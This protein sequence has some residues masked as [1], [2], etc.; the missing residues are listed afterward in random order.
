MCLS[1]PVQTHRHFGDSWG[2]LGSG[3]NRGYADQFGSGVYACTE[4]SR[5]E[6]E[7]TVAAENI[8]EFSPV[9]I[10]SLWN[11]EARDFTP[12][13][14]REDNLALLSSV[15]GMELEL[16]GVQV[17]VGPYWADIVAR[18]TNSD[19]LVVIENQLEKTNHDHLG[20]VLTYA[21]GL[22]SPAIV[23]IAREFSEDHR[24]AFDFLNEK[25]APDLRCFGI[26][27]QAWRIDDSRPAP[28]FRLVSS[29]NDYLTM[30]KSDERRITELDSLYL[31]FWSAFKEYC[32][33][34]GTTLKLGKPTTKHW[35]RMAVGRSKFSLNLTLSAQKKRAG[36]EIYIRGKT[37]KSAFGLLKE[38]RTAI[39]AETG[40]LEWQEL[41]H[42]Q[43]SRIAAYRQDA[44]IADR[45]DWD[46]LF[47]W[48]KDRGEL[49]H[50]VFAPMIRAL[51]IQESAEEERVDE[52]DDQGLGR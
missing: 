29:P 43:D 6:G 5:P 45:S 52:Y 46:D 1:N 40:R 33:S 11:D 13:L 24:R 18:D 14:A 17:Q 23:W 36:C 20:K 31:E 32:D 37:A 39:E 4:R 22:E 3:R 7:Y 9:D 34:R 30:I 26:E 12:W 47:A 19:A 25:A 38:R 35:F 41:P 27:I 51:P 50:R 10:R 2:I 21:A 8:G 44:D 48:L 28:L 49:F 42:R 15:L 16:E